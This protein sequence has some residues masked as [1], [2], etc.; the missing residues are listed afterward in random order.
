[1]V[2]FKIKRP[3]LV[4]PAGDWSSLHSAVSAGCDSVYFG[5]K[6]LSMRNLA[7][8]FDVLEL[9]KLM[10]VLRKERKKGYLA[11]NVIVYNKE[12]S[13]VERILKEA[14]TAGVDAVI[15]WDMAVFSMAK[16]LGLRIHFSIQAGVSNFRA[17]K[18]YYS[19]GASR[20]VL[21]RECSLS[22]IKTITRS[23]ERENIDCQIEAFIHGAMCISV[24]GRCFLSQY[25]FSKSANRGECLQPCRRLYAI[26]DV[27]NECEYRL[28]EDY[29]LSPKDLCA[30]DFIDRL[31]ESGIQ[32][33]KIEGR[34]RSPEYIQVTTSVYHQAIEDYFSGKFDDK[35]KEELKEKLRTVFNRGFS[36][37]FYLGDPS[38][39]LSR[40][41]Q[42]SHEKVYVGEVTKFYKKINVAEVLVR[43]EP[44]KKGDTIICAGKSTPAAFAT[45]SDIQID[46]KFVDRIERGQAAGLRLPFEVRRKDKVFIWRK[47]AQDK[48]DF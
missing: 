13:K 35:R 27:E 42:S 24:S 4:A 29:I 48:A 5:V 10:A 22:D 43:N 41:L 37:G 12:L 15:L 25:T 19:L 7:T 3:E 46:H 39:R 45:V 40:R 26:R 18:D 9:K 16:E 38:D 20:V 21:A 28:G 44:L 8:N 47:K 33:F 2:N 36:S 17:L 6:G 31:I 1:M 23:V 11:L 14:R 32:A 30:I 34:M